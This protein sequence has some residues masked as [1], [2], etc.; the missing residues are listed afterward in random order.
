MVIAIIRYLFYYY[1]HTQ[2]YLEFRELISELF[3]NNI[4]KFIDFYP[5]HNILGE[6]EPQN[7]GEIMKLLEKYAKKM[8]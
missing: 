6:P 4:E 2:D 7:E 1:R 5:D 8:K 3:E